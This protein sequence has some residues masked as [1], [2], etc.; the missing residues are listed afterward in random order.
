M[1]ILSACSS[2]IC[3]LESTS[4][5]SRSLRIP[6]VIASAIISAATPAATPVM[7]MTVTMPTTACLRL[8]FRYRAATPSSKRMLYFAPAGTTVLAA[9]TL[10]YLS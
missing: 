1:P 9:P 8:A 3:A 2:S 5:S 4:L 7:E 6:L 10:S